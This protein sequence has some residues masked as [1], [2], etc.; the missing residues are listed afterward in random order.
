MFEPALRDGVD[1]ELVGRC[2]GVVEAML[3]CP[4]R[5]VRDPAVIRVVPYLLEPAWRSMVGRYAGPV[6]LGELREQGFGFVAP[7][8]GGYGEYLAGRFPAWREA[9][10]KVVGARVVD[11]YVA[12]ALTRVVLVG[13]LRSAV[14]AADDE[15]LDRW[16]EAVDEVLA[17]PDDELTDAVLREVPRAVWE[18]AGRA[19][20]AHCGPLLVSAI[21]DRYGTGMWRAKGDWADEVEPRTKVSVEIYQYGGDLLM[22]GRR[23]CRLEETWPAV[24]P[25]VRTPV[26]STPD[27]IGAVV[28]GMLTE[29]AEAD[30]SSEPVHHLLD[31]FLEFVGGV[32]W[33]TLYSQSVL[34]TVEHLPPDG[35]LQFWSHEGTWQAGVFVRHP[36]DSSTTAYPESQADLGTSVL[37]ALD[38]SSTTG[39]G[40][41]VGE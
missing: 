23:Y 29:L 24:R 39:W 13:V 41:S 30:D 32:D 11:R 9:I 20:A 19:R 25:F 36:T 17:S 1:L 8:L 2:F 18:T 28:A 21:D 5:E 34:A 6:T 33:P 3:S 12:D 7:V 16:Y 31:E 35:G 27:E 22:H 10:G 40:G 37:A 26:A 15:L 38:R 14:E 4:D